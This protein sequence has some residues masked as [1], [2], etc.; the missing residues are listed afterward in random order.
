MVAPSNLSF[1][2][3]GTNPGDAL[4]WTRTS[5]SSASGF[6]A[7][8]YTASGRTR[9]ADGFEAQW[10]G[11]LTAAFTSDG[12]AVLASAGH[13]FTTDH[14]DNDQ[15]LVL[16]GTAPSPLAVASSQTPDLSYVYYLV[17]VDPGVSFGL[18]ATPGGTALNVT[19]GSGVVRE[20]TVEWYQADLSATGAKLFGIRD[21]FDWHTGYLFEG[22]NANVVTGTYDSVSVQR[23][24]SSWN[25][26]LANYRFGGREVGDVT[27]GTYDSVSAQRAS[28][29]LASLADYRTTRDPG[30]VTAGQY[31]VA[32]GA[33]TLSAEGF[34]AVFEAE[35][36]A[37]GGDPDLQSTNPPAVSTSLLFTSTD[38]L[39]AGF[40]LNTTYVVT[41]SGSGLFQVS[42]T[43]GGP[44]VTPTDSGAGTHTLTADTRYCWA[45]ME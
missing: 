3:A 21:S 44:V 20:P 26:S 9:R 6:G 36:T 32:K 11:T 33:P 13:P 10:G 25:Y 24:D 34:L 7:Y 14:E 12:S 18:S 39:P 2:T 40:A 27:T 30:D 4:A 31:A 29:W 42:T 1:E 5:T 16:T 17:D 38:T 19:T 8:A 22:P 23:F 15:C 43:S 45:A 28:N 37:I 41:S 35:F